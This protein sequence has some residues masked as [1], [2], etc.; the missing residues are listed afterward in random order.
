[1]SDNNPHSGHRERLR[2]RFIETGISGFSE[3]EILELLLFS[4]IPRANTNDLAHALL[5]RFGSL[6][7][8]LKSSPDELCSVK[9]IGSSSAFMLHLVGSIISMLDERAAE[10]TFF[11][12]S[13]AYL[14]SF[15]ASSTP[16]TFI[17]IFLNSRNNVISTRSASESAIVSG[18][19][20]VRN[21]LT[22]ILLTDARSVIIGICHGEDSTALSSADMNLL[23]IIRKPLE[24]IGTR[25]A[26]VIIK[27]GSQHFSMHESSAYML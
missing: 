9:G 7:E 2:K 23:K 1:M 3:H 17:M 18:E 10:G 5:D 22:D 11:S 20:S 8:V 12:T 24:G 4:S 25:I 26:D 27:G 21:I 13:Q 16:G 19:L 6:R 14:D 15:F